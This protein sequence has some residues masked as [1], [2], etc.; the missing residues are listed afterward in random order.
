MQADAVLATSASFVSYWLTYSEVGE[1]DSKLCYDLA[2]HSFETMS[3]TAGEED[4][5]LWFAADNRTRCL[6]AN[7]T[8]VTKQVLKKIPDF[9]IDIVVNFDRG[10]VSGAEYYGH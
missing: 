6:V 7:D 10:F 8:W 9:L 2:L 5:L 3:A 1:T 4:L